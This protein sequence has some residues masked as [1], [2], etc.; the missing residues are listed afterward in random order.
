MKIFETLKTD[1]LISFKLFGKVLYE[2][3]TEYDFHE[4]NLTTIRLQ[5][6]FGGFL[7]TKKVNQ[8]FGYYSDKQIIFLGVPVFKSVND[9]YYINY[10]CLN[11]TINKKSLKNEFKKSYFKYIDKKHDDIYI[12]NANSGEIYLFLTYIIDSLIKKNGSKAP[13]LIATKKY[14][15]D[16][17]KMLCP[18]IS[19]IYINSFSTEI[20]FNYF[21]I[22]DFKFHLI[23]KNGYFKQIEFIIK[24]SPLHACHY[25]VSMLQE[26][27]IS[28][29]DIHFHKAVVPEI[30]K[31]IVNDKISLLNLNIEKFIF[32]APEAQSCKLLSNK[33]WINL[34]NNFQDLG[35]DVFVNLVDNNIDLTGAK[36]KSCYLTYMEAFELACKAKKIVSLRSGFAEFLLQTNV[37][38]DVLYTK[39]KNRHFYNDMSVEQVMSGFA[40]NKLLHINSDALREFKYDINK[41]SELISM[42]TENIRGSEVAF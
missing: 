17:I 5:T 35:Y 25:F 39:F 7:K 11:K 30:V 1:S 23:F 10:F 14:H 29:D 15:L 33:F 28:K 42:I 40:L 20:R 32:I 12:L 16:M 41:E 8:E 36:Y 18:N 19:A 27:G 24:N 13:L 9:G 37:P 6:F 2:K 34:I 3:I 26:A 4:N 38:A 21:E 31:S 22:D